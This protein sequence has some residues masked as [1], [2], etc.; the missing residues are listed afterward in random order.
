MKKKIEF[1][2]ISFFLDGYR[3]S[4][5]IA[6]GNRAPGSYG[7]SASLYK[8]Q[9]VLFGGGDGERWFVFIFIFFLNGI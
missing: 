3:W 6:K 4:K 9:M 8:N 2:N 1:N 7:V 5:I